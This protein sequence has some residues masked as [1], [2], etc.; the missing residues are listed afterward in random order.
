MDLIAIA[1]EFATPEACFDFLDKKRWPEGVRC[2][3]CDGD[4]VS[5][6]V[7]KE[8]TRKRMS[9]RKGEVTV[10]VPA[11][12]LYQCLNSECGHQFTATTGTLFNDTHLPIQKWFFA[13]A[14]MTNA[15][16]GMSAKQMQ[17]DLKVSYQTA[18]YLCHRIRESMQGGASIFTGTV[19]AD[20]TFVGGR[21]DERRARAKYDKAA[22][23][24]V[25]QR[26]T[27]GKP[28]QVHAKHVEDVDKVVIRS[29]INER[30]SF[31]A[32]LYTDEG[33]VY[34][35]FAKTRNHAIVCHSK[36]EWVRGEVHT[37]SIEGFWSLVKRQII[38]QH[39]WVS[40][41][42]LQAYLNERVH[43]FN[44]R[45]AEDMFGMVI[46]ALLC[47]IALPYAVLTADLEVVSEELGDDPRS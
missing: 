23:V 24:G 29:I 12:H 25:L 30:V 16:K 8:G 35:Q 44:N 37:N 34:R 1:T 47:G 39:H 43:A 3:K 18:W 38:G 46:T 17:R 4:K 45:K 36:D 13:V 19:E 7:T 33:A 26:G 28:S 22:V 15:K 42:H 6:F 32:N 10:T 40:V 20:E 9:K 27:K 21:Y 5:K 2:L 14:L 11:R 41:K 31:D